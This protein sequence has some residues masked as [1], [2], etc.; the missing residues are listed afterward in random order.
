LK[1]RTLK[2]YIGKMM[3]QIILSLMLKLA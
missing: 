1:S 2:R 3:K